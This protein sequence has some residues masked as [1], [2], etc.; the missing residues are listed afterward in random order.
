M[1]HGFAAIVSVVDDEAKT[2]FIKTE[3][4][5][6]GGGFQQQMAEKFLI[7]RRRF[8]DARNGFFG[9]NQNVRG[10][11]RMKVAKGK[12]S[13]VLINDRRRNFACGNFFK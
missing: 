12:D 13:L 2:A 7:F 9:N 3:L 10:C 4:G 1:R 6:D 11:L 8:G 5:G